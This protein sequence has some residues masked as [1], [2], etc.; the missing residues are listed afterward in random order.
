MTSSRT[1]SP[2]HHTSSLSP[3]VSVASPPAIFVARVAMFGGIGLARRR[4]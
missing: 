3:P 4:G 2:D 1:P